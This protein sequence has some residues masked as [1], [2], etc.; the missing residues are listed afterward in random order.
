MNYLF[1][2]IA[3][4]ST[5]LAF[6]D[7]PC[8]AD[9]EQKYVRELKSK[10]ILVEKNGSSE[11]KYGIHQKIV[12]NDCFSPKE[13]NDSK[14]RLQRLAVEL[15]KKA[16][17]AKNYYA[18]SGPSAFSWY[19]GAGLTK[20]SERVLLLAVQKDSSNMTLMKSALEIARSHGASGNG[21]KSE[22]E[23]ISR[24]N[25]KSNLNDEEIES[26]K[27]NSDISTL[28]NATMVSCSKL[29]TAMEWLK[30]ASDDTAF[31]KKIA[32]KRGDTVANRPDKAMSGM[33]AQRF[34]EIAGATSK[35]KSQQV[36]EKK[37]Q[38]KME[39]S[40]ES[41]KKSM[42]KNS[43]E[44]TKKFQKGADDLEKELDL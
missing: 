10:L 28:A 19:E 29:L 35:L 3:L 23:K 26:K 40:S 38:L 12:K 34:Y 16:E 15:G 24:A 31:V 5:N 25:A 36:E 6:A 13:I 21:F 30:L 22:L 18:S 20:E 11:E 41:L 7:D 4:I 9:D 32:E 44:D 27:L 8:M 1:L 14:S 39:K 42:Q 2:L 37:M 43:A 33:M 17:V